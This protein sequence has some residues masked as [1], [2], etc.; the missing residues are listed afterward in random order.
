[1]ASLIL[2]LTLQE[3]T[4]VWATLEMDPQGAQERQQQQVK[5]PEGEDPG[6]RG[7]GL[8]PHGLRPP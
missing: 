3:V 1:M 6:V 2:S 7:E 8:S 5:V 4:F